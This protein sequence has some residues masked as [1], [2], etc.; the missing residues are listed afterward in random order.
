MEAMLVSLREHF[1]IRVTDW[2]LSA[3]L[4]SWGFCLIWTS[5]AVWALP[6]F[7]GLARI[8][9]QCVWA[10]AA[11][12][13]GVGRLSALFINGALRRSPHARAAGA[14]LSC[15]IWVQLTLGMIGADWAGPGIGIFPWLALA[16]AFNVIR[17]TADARASDERAKQQQRLVAARGAIP[18]SRA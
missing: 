16:D 10:A 17:A 13:I 4:F 6:T 1:R 8:A 2:L 11:T 18:S 12:I 15:F 3:I 7:T 5:P 9:P 14:F